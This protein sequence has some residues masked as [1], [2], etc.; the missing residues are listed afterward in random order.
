MAIAEPNQH[1]RPREREQKEILRQHWGDWMACK[2]QLD[3]SHRRSIVTYLCDHPTDFRRAIGL[4]RIDL[5]SIYVAA[6]QSYLWN[7]W[8]SSVF[9]SL[10]PTERL[11]WLDS[12]CGRLAVPLEID[13]SL[14]L[15]LREMEL[16]LPSARIREWPT[17]WKGLLD[18][19]LEELE[20]TTS[21]I[22]LKYPRDT[23]FSKG[24]EPVGQG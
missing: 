14:A 6:F 21:E 1:D 17:K 18:Q 4:V 7:R 23:F 24:R 9:Q 5:R 19:L 13:A 22:R 11:D 16:P 15:E 20:M 8:L 10:L 2:D 12:R 3:R